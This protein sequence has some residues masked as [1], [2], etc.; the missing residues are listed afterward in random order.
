MNYL[1]N[2]QFTEKIFCTIIVLFTSF[3]SI[4]FYNISLAPFPMFAFLILAF[5]LLLFNKKLNKHIIFIGLLFIILF[6][7]SGLIGKF[8]EFNVF[9]FNSILGSIIGPLFF[10]L[11]YSLYYQ[12]INYVE[13]ALR[14]VIIFH[15][16]FFIIQTITFYLTGNL[17]N[18]LQYITGEESR[19]I[20]Y[21]LLTGLIRPSGLFNEPA[22]YVTF[23]G[24]SLLFLIL[25]N[26][27]LGLFEL[28]T[29]GS[30]LL[31]LSASGVIISIYIL[32]I[33]F[34]IV[35]KKRARKIF[36]SYLMIL[37]L[38]LTLLNLEL[39]ELIY[40][41][42]SQRFILNPEIDG[43]VSMRFVDG[44]K[45]FFSSPF[46]IQ[47]FG[48][49]I[50]NYSPLASTVASGFMAIIVHL[51]YL[52]TLIFLIINIFSFRLM[53]VDLKYFLI[54]SFFLFTTITYLFIHYWFFLALIFFISK[55]NNTNTIKK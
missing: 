40:K 17:I 51:G 42:F 23:I 24:P 25:Y 8:F 32:A 33:Y 6:S 9:Y 29:L 10:I 41:S 14:K 12:K 30:I 18:F 44:F 3:F 47:L 28:I 49:G 22:S 15:L 19:N 27:K 38:A 46:Y 2:T 45:L 13:Y 54:F 35:A 48:F 37:F 50:G 34:I 36:F 16:F 52:F 20:A 1:I 7:I 53:K 39:I 11:F 31:T 43:S 26:K 55:N 5:I 4:Y 21:G